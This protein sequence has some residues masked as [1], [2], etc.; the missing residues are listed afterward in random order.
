M[1]MRY[2]I[3]E[4]GEVVN[5]AT[6]DSALAENWIRSD[7]GQIGWAYESD[8]FTAPVKPVITP[9]VVTM[10]QARLA[11]HQLDLLGTVETAVANANANVKIECAY[12]ATVERSHPWVISLGASLGLD[13][14]D[15]FTIAANL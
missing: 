2:C 13:L 12:S 3:V 1:T 10:R 6:S 11:L 7:E 8:V 9:A 15:L 4:N 5:V 14:D